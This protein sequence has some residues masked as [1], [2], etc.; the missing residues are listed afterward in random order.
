ML[1]Y[2]AIWWRSSRRSSK[3]N[4]S[5]GGFPLKVSVMM[6]TASGALV[7]ELIQE[8]AQR[9]EMRAELAAGRVDLV[10]EARR[11]QERAAASAS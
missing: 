7:N 5:R 10:G 3:E 11:R 9:A 4:G 8:E 6:S 1:K 2:L